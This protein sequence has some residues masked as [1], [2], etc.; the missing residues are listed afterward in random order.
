MA[1]GRW[2][3][4]GSRWVVHPLIGLSKHGFDDVRDRVISHAIAAGVQD[5]LLG[6]RLHRADVHLLVVGQLG[7]LGGSEDQPPPD[8]GLFDDVRLARDA[9]SNQ[10]GR[11]PLRF[12]LASI[13]AANAGHTADTRP[14]GSF[15]LSPSA[16]ISPG[17]GNRQATMASSRRSA[18]WGLGKS[19]ARLR[20]R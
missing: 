7:Y 15:S 8:S 20:S 18:G 13:A 5:R 17:Q 4:R 12:A 16:L 14:C 6:L 11:N 1:G 2:I 19:G 3:I 9:P 10:A